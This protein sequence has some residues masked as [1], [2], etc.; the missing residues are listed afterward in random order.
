MELSRILRKV[1]QLGGS[2]ECPQMDQN[3]QHRLSGHSP[4]CLV[5]GQMAIPTQNQ[6]LPLSHLKW[7]FE[8]VPVSSLWSHC[9]F[10]MNCPFLT[11]SDSLKITTMSTQEL[12]SLVPSVPFVFIEHEI[13]LKMPQVCPLSH[14]KPHNFQKFVFISLQSQTLCHSQHRST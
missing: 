7:L 5:T 10:L 4:V 8:Q 11:N 1:A 14:W 6:S 12:S 9:V 2:L 13:L 3:Y